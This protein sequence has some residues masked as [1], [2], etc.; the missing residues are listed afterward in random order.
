MMRHQVLDEELVNK[1]RALEIE[2]F[3]KHGV[4][5]KV[6]VEE[7]GRVKG[8]KPIGVKW[9]DL[10]KRDAKNPEYRPRLVAKEIK[11]DKREKI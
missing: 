4:Y 6:P 3:K 7:F 5:S 1:A 9:I 11:R 8:K 10:S 2:T